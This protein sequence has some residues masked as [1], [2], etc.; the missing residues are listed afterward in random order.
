MKR[1]STGNFFGALGEN[2]PK[3]ILRLGHCLPNRNRFDLQST[4]K[5]KK[6]RLGTPS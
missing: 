4:I 1:C 2:E 3:T 6:V 5:A